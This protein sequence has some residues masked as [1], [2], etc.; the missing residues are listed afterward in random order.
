M[1]IYQIYY[2]Y[3]IYTVQ[4][5]YFPIMMTFVIQSANPRTVQRDN[6]KVNIYI[7][8]MSIFVIIRECTIF[9]FTFFI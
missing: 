2:L 5:N 4:G 6:L 3:I 8:K 1:Y 9:N 7:F